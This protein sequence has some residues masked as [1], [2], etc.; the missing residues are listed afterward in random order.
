[1]TGQQ[2]LERLITMSAEQRS[3]EILF[4]DSEFYVHDVREVTIGSD[5][6]ILTDVRS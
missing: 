1:M 4:Y 5:G 2:L 6:I 3:A